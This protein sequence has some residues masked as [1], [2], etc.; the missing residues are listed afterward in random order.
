MLGVSG[1]SGMLGL[2]LGVIRRG[3]HEVG[4]HA[5]DAVIVTV[6][7]QDVASVP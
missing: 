1:V 2:R 3:R 4:V 7:D 6:G 5:P